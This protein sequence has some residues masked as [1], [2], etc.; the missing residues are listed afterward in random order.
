MLWWKERWKLKM[1][2]KDDKYLF[3]EVTKKQSVHSEFTIA[4]PC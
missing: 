3:K 4:I 1:R 2:I